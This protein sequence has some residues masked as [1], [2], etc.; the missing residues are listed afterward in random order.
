MT[1]VIYGIFAINVILAMGRAYKR[2]KGKKS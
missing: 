2:R 1:Y